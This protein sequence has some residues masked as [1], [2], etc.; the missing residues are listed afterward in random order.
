MLKKSE[1]LPKISIVI[2]SFNKASYIEATLRS[3][4]DQDYPNLEVIIQDGQSTDGTVEVVK[5]YAKKYSKLFKWES[6]KD[7]G[8]VDAINKGF[9]KATGELLAY[10]NADDVYKDGVLLEVGQYFQKHPNISWITGYGDIIDKD[11]KVI[12]RLVTSYKNFL[13][14]LN[15]YSLLLIINFISQPSTF[16][17]RKAYEN[18]GPFTGT[19]NYVMEY[20]LWLRLGKIQMPLVI[21]KTLSS[22]R[23]TSGNISVTSVKELLKIDNRITEKYTSSGLLLA[24][25]KLHNLGRIFLLNFM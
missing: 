13:L 17:S 1:S 12:A 24:L 23:L 22:F 18:F 9:K 5:K 4:I 14:N 8:Q 15:N 21:K 16:F 20:D 19:K 25:H 7:N 6:K 10:I 3:I 11:G 2:P